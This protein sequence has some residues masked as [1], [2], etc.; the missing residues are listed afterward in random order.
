MTGILTATATEN[1]P[2]AVPVI[3]RLSSLPGPSLTDLPYLLHLAVACLEKLEGSVQVQGFAQSIL[4]SDQN[5]IAH[6]PH[7]SLNIHQWLPNIQHSAS[8]S[9][10]LIFSVLEMLWK[11]SMTLDRKCEAWEKLTP[12]ILLW[13]SIVFSAGERKGDVTEWARKEVVLNL[14]SPR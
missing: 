10:S 5:V 3:F 14:K 4:E 6:P 7:R 9:Q 1:L 8:S 11:T 13:R 12:R 2:H